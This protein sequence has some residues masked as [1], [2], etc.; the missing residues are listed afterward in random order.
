[1]RHHAHV[2]WPHIW[3]E[4]RVALSSHLHMHACV[5]GAC[6]NAPAQAYSSARYQPLYYKK[7]NKLGLRRKFGDK[8]Q[9]CS[10][11][12]KACG[13]D[14]AGLRHIG[15]GCLEKLDAG[16]SESTVKEWAAGQLA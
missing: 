15:D 10:F 4:G 13:K 6:M 12:G 2:A 1:M 7:D 8:A 16:E 11:G 9:F 14:E 5:A 3:P